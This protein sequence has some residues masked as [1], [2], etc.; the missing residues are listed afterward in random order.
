M[1]KSCYKLVVFYIEFSIDFRTQRAEWSWFCRAGVEYQAHLCLSLC[2]S[3]GMALHQKVAGERSGSGSAPAQS[4]L[5]QQRQ[6][7]QA[8]R[9]LS[10]LQP[11]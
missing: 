10:R 5:A 9:G 2:V 7:T 11:R 4:F 6:W 3:Q 1:L 8:R